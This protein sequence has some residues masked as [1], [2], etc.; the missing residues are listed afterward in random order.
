MTSPDKFDVLYDEPELSKKTGN[1]DS[2]ILHN[3]LVTIQIRIS[4]LAKD[5]KKHHFTHRKR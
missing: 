2:T 5:N 1:V 4:E 3:L